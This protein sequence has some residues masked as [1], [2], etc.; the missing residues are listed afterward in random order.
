MMLRQLVSEPVLPR[1]RVV[2]VVAVPNSVAYNSRVHDRLRSLNMP[3]LTATFVG[4]LTIGRR[5]AHPDG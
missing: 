3:R 4:L 1:E 2:E 5:R